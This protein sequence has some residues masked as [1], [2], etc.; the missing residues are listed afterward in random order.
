MAGL[1]ARLLRDSETGP[2]AIPAI[3]AILGTPPAQRIAESQESQGGD[4]EKMQAWADYLDSL[5]EGGNVVPLRAKAGC[6]WTSTTR[7]ASPVPLRAKA[8]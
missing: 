3:P 8:G 6:S 5:R 2:A 4:A 7:C 1:L